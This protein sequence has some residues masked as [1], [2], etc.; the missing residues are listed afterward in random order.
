M[1]QANDTYTCD[2]QESPTLVRSGQKLTGL[3]G[4]WGDVEPRF[5]RFTLCEVV[6][7][8]YRSKLANLVSEDH[9]V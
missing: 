8:W 5:L 1:N 3:W 6:V 7:I 4:I 2:A 9:Q